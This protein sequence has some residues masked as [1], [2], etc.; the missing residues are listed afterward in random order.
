M[1]STPMSTQT[2]AISLYS[3]LRNEVEILD[4][5]RYGLSRNEVLDEIKVSQRCSLSEHSGNP[6]CPSS[7]DL[8]ITEIKVRQ[9]CALRQHS[10]KVLG[11]TCLNV[12]AVEMEFDQR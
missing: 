11:P 1:H 3:D 9:R 8:V 2:S 10:S 4:R 6:L 7:I 12:I 5:S